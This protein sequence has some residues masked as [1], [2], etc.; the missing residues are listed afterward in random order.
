MSWRTKGK[1]ALSLCAGLAM[2]IG[3]SACGGSGNSSS[4]K[5]AKESSGMTMSD[6]NKALKS[7]KKVTLN[8]WTW[9]YDIE[10]AN[11]D[12]FQAKYPNIKINV[13]QTGASSDHY[14]KFQNIL[15]SGKD[16]PDIVQ[17]EYDYL[18]QFAVTNSLLNFADKSIESDMGKLYNDAA[19]K[20]VHVADGLYGTP[21]DQG[22]E[23]MFVRHDVLDQF[24]LK[25]PTTWKEFEEEGI[26]LHKA[27]PNRYMSFIDT[28]DVRYMA[29]IIRQS[30]AKPWTVKGVQDVTLDM[31]NSKVKEAVDFIQK[32]IDEDVLEPVAN[33]SD[34]YNRGFA[35]GR[36]G[37]QFDGC[38]KGTSFVQQQP[39][40]KGKFEVA[41]PP[42]WGDG[43]TG[44]KTGEIGGSLLS[45]T[46][47]CAKE[48]QAAAVAFINWMGSDKQ[49]IDLFQKTGS[50]FN[51][52]KSF[53]TD[54]DAAN[55][56]NDYFGGQKVNAVYFKSADALNADWSVLP[57][58]SQYA[59]DFKDIVVP[60]MKKGG[61]LFGSFTK[62]Q[63]SLK[64]YA[65]GQGFRIT[66]K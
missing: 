8:F 39:S 37:I 64:T 53:Q 63:S 38:W 32:L 56:P 33:K 65:D 35:Q 13:T 61:D 59:T 4:S 43:S 18:P 3:L 54:K 44:L 49:S 29:S 40:L 6:V 48:K 31:T 17:L 27:D 15:K 62:W 25:V 16:V 22:P 14:T 34:Q 41:L 9:R 5:V 66:V 20:N 36:W 55:V 19:W 45:V 11:I 21:L 12:A 51:A 1:Q 50:F 42:A 2:I 60:Q 10:Q 7:D 57:F 30:G 46:S 52:A 23:V 28:T 47:K 58:N 24:G 26:A